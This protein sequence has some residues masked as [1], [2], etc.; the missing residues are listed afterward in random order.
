MT[1]RILQETK[2]VRETVCA[3][4]GDP[5]LE[6]LIPSK[7][8]PED[9][10]NVLRCR[11]CDLVFLDAQDHLQQF[12]AEESEYW[13]NQDQKKVYLER[14]V[15][16]GFIR[17]FNARLNILEKI[18]PQ[19][20][21]L[22]DVGCG[23]GHFLAE[24]QKRGWTVKGLDIS[25]GAKAAA[26]DIYGID[27]EVGSLDGALFHS[28]RFDVITLWDVIEHM[29]KP[30]E[31]IHHAHHL[32]KEG[33][34]LVLKTP[35]ERGLFKQTALA[36]YRIFGTPAAFL[37]K[38]VYYLPHYFSYSKKS[39]NYLLRSAGFEMIRFELD[40]TP[41]EFAEGKINIHYKKDPKRAFVIS[42]IP[43]ANRIGRL[44]RKG[45]KMIVYARKIQKGNDV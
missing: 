41:Y 32:L 17:E 35:N 19:K 37:L 5:D 40:E 13:N 31:N 15:Q 44:L 25:S 3:F 24:A 28:E 18:I 23:V 36:L 8:L 33:G 20:G 16:K 14:D 6:I 38:Y 43:M 7:L 39:M 12:E 11:K 1:N 10:V 9:D 26:K 2:N 4:C 42:M 34:L 27:V 45:N 30:L 22:L 21:M 29:R